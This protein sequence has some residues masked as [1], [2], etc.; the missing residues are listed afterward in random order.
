MLWKQKPS[1]NQHVRHPADLGHFPSLAGVKNPRSPREERRGG[2]GGGK[3]HGKGARGLKKVKILEIHEGHERGWR[4]I[5]LSP[6]QQARLSGAGALAPVSAGV[7]AGRR[8]FPKRVRPGRMAPRCKKSVRRRVTPAKHLSHFVSA[9]VCTCGYG[10]LY[11]QP[12]NAWRADFHFSR[13]V[14]FSLPKAHTARGTRKQP[15]PQTKGHKHG[16]PGVPGTG[17]SPV[18]S[19]S[20]WD[21]GGNIG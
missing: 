18:F 3:L 16:H 17:L 4:Q 6:P 13:K 7:S 20:V 2:G 5:R 19:P 9:I 8:G 10:W 1:R 12:P 14:N 11:V 15:P 21:R